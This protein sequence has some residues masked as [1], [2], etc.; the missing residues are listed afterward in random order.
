M[1]RCKAP[2]TD[3]E[4][5]IVNCRPADFVDIMDVIPSIQLDI[6]YYSDNNFVGRRIKGYDAPLC[7]LTKKAALALR[8]VQDHLVSCGFSLKIYDGYRPQMAVDDFATWAKDLADEKMKAEYYPEVDKA[9]LFSDG[10]IAY[11]SGHSRGSTVDCCIVEL[12]SE[13]PPYQP[14]VPLRSCTNCKDNRALNNSMDF[15]TGF[16]CFSPVSHPDY[17][18]L[19]LAIRMNRCMLQGLMA[20]A[21]FKPLQEEWWHFTLIDEPYKDV[22]FNFP[23][24]PAEPRP[25]CYA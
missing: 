13:V 12:G 5:K 18:D 7:L 23:V 21:G 14:L 16:D 4:P 10:Y 6:R 1:I 17:A 22:A 24:A 8:T 25:C 3:G 11:H 19:G 15:G 2:R 9:D 20:G